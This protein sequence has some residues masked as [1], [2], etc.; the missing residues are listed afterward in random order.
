MN[1]LQGN[2]AF[3]V[4]DILSDKKVLY[5]ED[6]EGIAKNIAEVLKLFFLKV[7]EV[8]DG[9]EALNELSC[10]SYDV[11][12]FDISMPNM[13]GLEAIEEIRKTNKKI[14]III[15][16]AHTE[17]EYLWRAVELKITKYLVKPYSKNTLIQALEQASLELVDFHTTINLTNDCIYNPCAKIVCCGKEHIKLSKNESRLLEYFIKRVNQTVTFDE[18]YDYIWEFEVPSKEAIKSIV[19]ELRKKIGKDLIK[20]IYGTGY[21]LEIW[22][23]FKGFIIFRINLKAIIA[24]FIVFYIIIAL[25]F[26]SFYKQLVIEDAKQE[27]TSILKTTNALRSYIENI[28]KPIIYKLQLDGKLY[29]DFFSPKILSAS[30]ISRNIHQRYSDIQ[31]LQNK[32]HYKYK[33]AATNPRNPENKA[34]KFETKILNQFR[35]GEIKEF[36]TILEENDQEYFFT[37]IPIDKNKRSCMR[38]HSKP[39]FAPKDLIKLYGK[40]AGFNEKIGDIRAI[41]SLKIPLSQII[42]NH[43]KDF[44]ISIFIVL[45]IFIIFYIFIYIIYKKDIKLQNEREKLLMH[46]NKLA[47]MGEMIGNIAHQWRQPLTQLSSI[48]I[49]IELHFDRN[50]LTKEQLVNKIEEANGQISFMSDTIDDF[51]NFFASGKI[52]KDYKIQEVVELSKHLMSASLDKNNIQLIIDIQNNFNLN[53]YPNEVTQALVNIINNAKDVLIQ[54]EIKNCLII[55]KTFINDNHNI[56]TIQDNAGGI[57]ENIID[58]I[59]EPY[60]STKHAS[61]GTGIG[62]YMT[63]TIIEKN[64]DGKIYTKNTK[65]GAIF[66]IMF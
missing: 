54:R 30:Y 40:I 14:P 66:T 50:K 45:I 36:S 55:I 31:K 19:K 8:R 10:S 59:F 15:L 57:P 22:F 62:L 12:M 34:D 29:K 64:N 42:Q 18:I 56:I 1:N 47:S 9:G 20:N 43:I 4:L 5:A 21:I 7:V 49:N 35:N 27:V 48:L 61:I 38:C 11:L 13:D 28:Q 41:I 3:D 26:Y 44:F 52:K 6:E 2:E 39:E 46:Q 17:Q 60:F 24:F 37:A 25:S 65:E 32:I 16:S 23:H 51:R 58:K 53:G 33:L 63:K